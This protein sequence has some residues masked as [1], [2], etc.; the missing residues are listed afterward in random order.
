MSGIFSFYGNKIMTTGEGGMVVTNDSRVAERARR[1]RDHG[2]DPDLHYWHPEIG[3]NYRMTNLQAA[4]GGGEA[5]AAWCNAAGG[6]ERS[7]AGGVVGSFLSWAAIWQCRNGR[8]FTFRRL[9][10]VPRRLQV[11][12]SARSAWRDFLQKTPCA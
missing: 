11:V 7:G 8:L 9:G 5:V 2:A 10:V 3:Y 12:F 1:L 6:G 4:L